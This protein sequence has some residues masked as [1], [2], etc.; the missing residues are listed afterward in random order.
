[1]NVIILHLS[2][3]HI[4]NEKDPVLKQAEHI[5]STTFSYLP[6]AE[7]V[8]ILVSGDIAFSGKEGQY[9]L[10][11]TFLTEIRQ[12]I[13]REKNCPVHFILCP[14]NHDC[15]LRLDTTARQL[16]CGSLT[17]QPKI[18]DSVIETCTKVQSAFFAFRRRIETGITEI[19]DGLWRA[20]RYSASGMSLVFECLNDSWASSRDDTFGK[21]PF[22]LERYQSIPKNNGDIRIAV[23]HH[24]VHWAQQSIYR[25][26]RKFVRDRASMVVTGHEHRGNIGVI[27]ETESGVSA[28]IE[29]CPLQTDGSLAESAFNVIEIDLEQKKFK[30]TQYKFE[31]N[32]YT[33]KPSNSWITYRDLPSGQTRDFPLSKDFSSKLNDFG[34]PL[35]HPRGGDINLHD[36]YVYPDLVPYDEQEGRPRV[37]KSSSELRKVEQ[38]KD[39]LIIQGGEK[40]GKTSLLYQLYSHYYEHGYVPVLLNGAD[41]KRS[42]DEELDRCI[43]RAVASQ[44]GEE[45]VEKFAQSPREKKIL[46]LDDFD[47]SPSKSQKIR[48]KILEG[49]QARFHCLILTVGETFE[50]RQLLESE[51]ADS[52]QRFRRFSIQPF[53]YSLR[54]ALIKKWYSIGGEVAVD[55]GEILARCEHAERVIDDVMFTT[56]VP[57]VPLYLLTLLYSIEGSRE[58]EFKESALGYYYQ[59]LLTAAFGNAG[60]DADKLTEVFEYASHLA[61]EFKKQG[62]THL[63]DPELRAFN[64]NFSERWHTVSYEQRIEILVRA[65]IL[66]KSGDDYAFRYPY[67]YY[68]L[69]A[70]YLSEFLNEAETRRYIQHCCEHLYVRDNAS[71]ILFLAHH[72]NDNFVVDAIRATQ[73]KMFSQ[74]VPVSFNGDTAAVEKL[75]EDAPRIVYSGEQPAD[76]HRRKDELLDAVGNDTDGLATNEEE[77]QEL[78][79][80]AQ[81]T[82]LIKTT[83]ILGQVLKNQYSK[84]ERARRQDL[85]A[86]LFNG[87]LRALNHLFE[88]CKSN[89]N[90]FA[91]E[92]EALLKKREVINDEE[93]RK[94][95]A[96]K[97][98]AGIIQLITFGFLLTSARAANSE[99]LY[100]DVVAVVEKSG[101]MAF[102]LLHLG[103]R[104]DSPKDMPKSLLED[105]YRETEGKML[106]SR[107]V[108][109]MVIRRLYMFKTRERDMQWLKDKLKIGI[110]QQH[111]IT[112]QQTRG[113]RIR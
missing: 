42:K 15:D 8:F 56:V 67:V 58:G 110:D 85:L 83:E 63:S 6:A 69:K 20:T 84:I 3:I 108:R 97:L 12:S 11:T 68:F 62:K 65:K 45:S 5:A 74:C 19:D 27:N 98:A 71:T 41:L 113:R 105:L 81:L 104:L 112:Y 50:L 25:D 26:L 53:G 24:P 38:I 64:K 2:D 9:Q 57:S 102:K 52:L 103:I 94:S 29:G 80:P 106:P 88:F 75:I 37:Y 87:P 89:P 109:L 7:Q 59:Y 70:K 66:A 107:M 14:G 82:M 23:L 30:A 101:T 44:Y 61:W 18:D 10:A 40:Y 17:Q 79:F 77:G 1:M 47:L 34:S 16:V 21:L 92:I 86:D 48:D 55:D 96:K 60:V 78:S 90:A 93:A 46:F 51:P 32:H 22:P 13:I 72:T 99:S 28:F 33:S 111:A 39:N 31:Q 54:A 95:A 43:T 36:I 49:F 100:E 91:A 76:F 73:R 4:D 35:K